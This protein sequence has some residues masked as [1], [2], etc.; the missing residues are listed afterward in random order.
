VPGRDLDA[1]RLTTLLAGLPALTSMGWLRLR[2]DLH[3]RPT[4]TAA[5]A[6]LAGAMR[7]IARCSGL[8]TLRLRITLRDGLADQLPETLVR[9]LA[10]VRSLEEVGT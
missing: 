2:A 3:R 4:A 8:Q 6:F 7:A 5:R 10:S 1:G 9:E